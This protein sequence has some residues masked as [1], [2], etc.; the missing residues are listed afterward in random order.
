MLT[1]T[2]FDEDLAVSPPILPVAVTNPPWVPHRYLKEDL[3]PILQRAIDHIPTSHLLL[4]SKDET[5]NTPDDAWTRLQDY[6]F[7]QGFAIVNKH[8]AATYYVIH[9]QIGL[10]K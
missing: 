4:P 8:V 5:F 9:L 2:K 6:A 10:M 1:H 7:S 3:H